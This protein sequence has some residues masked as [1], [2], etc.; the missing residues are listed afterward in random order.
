[1][2]GFNAAAFTL[3]T[4]FA[5]EAVPFFLCYNPNG[6]AFRIFKPHV[7]NETE[8][9]CTSMTIVSGAV[10]PRGFTNVLPFIGMPYMIFQNM[11]DPSASPWF[12]QVERGNQPNQ[13]TV[14]SWQMSGVSNVQLAPLASG[15]ANLYVA[16]YDGSQHTLTVHK[17]DLAAK[18]TI[19]PGQSQPWDGT[20]TAF[21]P[22]YDGQCFLCFDKATGAVRAG[23][24]DGDTVAPISFL[25]PPDPP[26]TG[27]DAL[28]PLQA[29]SGP[30]FLAYKRNEQNTSPSVYTVPGLVTSGTPHFNHKFDYDLC[31]SYVLTINTVLSDVIIGQ[32]QVEYYLIDQQPQTSA[33][34]TMQATTSS[35]LMIASGMK[36]TYPEDDQPPPSRQDR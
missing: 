22:L 27:Y 7:S 5:M 32:G 29:M 18:T 25:N 9:H 26:L 11:N 20:W 23:K 34:T 35:P 30:T 4:P 17:I 36:P 28:T 14:T 15:S 10:L 24:L 13:Y 31:P 8:F 21:A 2:Q 12:V 33:V 1:M 3:F 16:A 19:A 6:G